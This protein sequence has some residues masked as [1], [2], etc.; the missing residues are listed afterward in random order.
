MRSENIFFPKDRASA[1]ID[2]GLFSLCLPILILYRDSLLEEQIVVTNDS[3]PSYIT[4]AGD[5][6][7]PARAAALALDVKAILTP[8]CVSH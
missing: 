1:I 4:G 7:L 6:R 2:E 8:P 5:H 3:A